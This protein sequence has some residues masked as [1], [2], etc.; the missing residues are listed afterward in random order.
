MAVFLLIVTILGTVA[1]L[2][3]MLMKKPQLDERTR[4]LLGKLVTRNRK[5]EQLAAE[6]GV[7]PGEDE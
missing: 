7:Q 2:I 6:N 3:L 5:L 4:V 1:E